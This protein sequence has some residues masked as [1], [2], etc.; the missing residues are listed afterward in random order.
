M[1]PP[2][3]KGWQPTRPHLTE[4]LPQERSSPSVGGELGLTRCWALRQV[5]GSQ[6]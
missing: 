3:R 6:P 4:P 2:L 5:L 1:G